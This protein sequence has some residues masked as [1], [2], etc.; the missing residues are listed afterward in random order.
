MCSD[1]RKGVFSSLPLG[2]V[3]IPNR[4]WGD[5]SHGGWGKA[6]G[7]TPYA[8]SCQTQGSLLSGSDAV[9]QGLRQCMQCQAV[10]AF[11]SGKPLFASL[12]SQGQIPSE[13]VSE[14]GC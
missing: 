4:F 8:D 3:R 11:S 10:D 6:S 5:L 14:M 2:R 13:F 12:A 1:H 9:G 7:R